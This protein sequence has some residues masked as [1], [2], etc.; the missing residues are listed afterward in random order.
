MK[1]VRPAPTSPDWNRKI[2]CRE[3]L[4]ILR[5]ERDDLF[6]RHL[7]NISGDRDVLVCICL[8][9]GHDIKIADGGETDTDEIAPYGPI[10]TFEEWSHNHTVPKRRKIRPQRSHG[11]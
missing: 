11:M 4:A 9:C 10:P 7:N 1:L 8:H 6:R 3:C 5:V 2:K